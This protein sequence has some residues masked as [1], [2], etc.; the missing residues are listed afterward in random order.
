MEEAEI[1]ADF[2]WVVYA[3]SLAAAQ[4]A[5]SAFERKWRTRCPSVARSLQECGEELLTF[6]QFPKRQWKMLRT[7]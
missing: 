6:Y 3:G 1:R 5:F 7:T 2:H 4:S